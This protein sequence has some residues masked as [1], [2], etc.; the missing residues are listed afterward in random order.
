MMTSR[1]RML[2]SGLGMAAAGSLAKGARAAASTGVDTHGIEHTSVA[3][4]RPYDDLVRGF[5]AELGRWDPA[6]RNRLIETKASWSDLER[7][8]ARMAG[9]RGLM[10]FTRINQG[11]LFA[12]KGEIRQCS[13]YLVGNPV[14]ADEIISID[15]RGSFYVPFRV[16]L[17]DQ[18]GA[19]GAV[20]A[21]DR[22]SSFLA[23]LGRHELTEIGILLD[24]KIDAVVNALRKS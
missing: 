8:V 17:F 1:R 22:P 9:P 2:L 15:V 11:E 14:I 18:G 12:L 21:F 7:E 4:G 13:L 16:G 6:V 19:D 3:T 23:S 20:I 24:Q 10:I 5:E